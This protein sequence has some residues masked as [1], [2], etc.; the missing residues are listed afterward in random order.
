ME[1]SQYSQCVARGHL[2]ISPQWLLMGVLWLSW[3]LNFLDRQLLA[4]VA[5]TLK[6]EFQLSNT[7][8]GGLISGFYLVYA[9]ATPLS[10]L[11][12]DRVGL[13]IGA[14]VAA[15]LWSLAGAATAMANSFRGLLACRMGL[16][17]GESAGFPLLGKATASYLDPAEMG[18]AGGFGAISISLGSIAAP[19]IVSAMS[20]RFGW[21]SVFVLS[22]LLGL[23]WA[24]LWL[25]TSR[26]IPPRAEIGDE[27]YTPARDLLRDRR[28]WA[29]ALAYSLVF[30]LYMLWANWTTIYLVQERHLSQLE[31]NTRYAWFPPAFAVLGGFLGGAVAF[32]LIRGG[33]GGLAA[34]MRV[35]WLTAPLLLAGASIPFLPSTA[36]AAA[37]IGVSFLAYQSILGSLFLVPLDMFGA[38]HAGLTNSLLAFVATFAQVFVSPAIGAVVDQ[39][40]FTVLCVVVALLPLFGLGILQ[41]TLR[42]APAGS[43]LPH[44]R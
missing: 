29:V 36:L 1:D 38:R 44:A 34:R 12:V 21:R 8:Y 39:L 28:L 15:T 4:S 9:L 10:G 13:R 11:F 25:F 18:L 17:L 27:P 23:L 32:A 14:A 22:G 41:W 33:M 2:R 5:P 26:R 6:A 16:G 20:P 19:L 31:A 40:G 42:Q 43:L 35:C 24:P 3:T 7:Q 37:A 30:T